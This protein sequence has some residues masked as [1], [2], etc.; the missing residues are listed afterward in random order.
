MIPHLAGALH[1]PVYLATMRVPDW[2][3]QRDGETSPWYPT[4]RLFRQPARGD[5]DDVFRRMAAAVSAM[6][7]SPIK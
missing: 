1:R 5:W 7:E 2:R 6:A 3:W 4:M